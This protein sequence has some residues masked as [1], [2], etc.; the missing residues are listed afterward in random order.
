MF[1]NPSMSHCPEF[2][3]LLTH[4]TFFEAA[5]AQWMSCLQPSYKLVLYSRLLLESVPGVVYKRVVLQTH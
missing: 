3:R 4:A 1:M 5:I 2:L